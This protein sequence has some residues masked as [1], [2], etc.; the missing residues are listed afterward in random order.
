MLQQ[1]RAHNRA[2]AA[3]SY[4]TAVAFGFRSAIST[5]ARVRMQ[6]RD[7]LTEMERE[8]NSLVYKQLPCRFN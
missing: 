6:N 4:T 8:V 5:R 7:E 3:L 2:V 1:T